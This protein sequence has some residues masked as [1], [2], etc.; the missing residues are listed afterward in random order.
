MTRTN[1]MKAV[2]ALLAVPAL[3]MVAH[4]ALS[5]NEAVTAVPP[6]A[7]DRPA[8]GGMQ[9]IVLA[10][11]CF[12]GLQGLFE[13]VRG[14]QQV[15][16]GYAGGSAETARY[17]IV[18]TGSTG[19]AESVEIT[20][21]PEVVSYGHLLQLY[22]SVA[23]DP[24]QIGGQGPDEGTQYRSAIFY[25]DPDQK[26]VADAYIAQIDTSNVFGRRLATRL[27][28]LT[29]FFPAEAYHQDYLVHHPSNPYIVVNDLPKISNLKRAFP[30]DYRSEPATIAA[31]S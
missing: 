17:P 30:E 23:H 20:Y 26:R 8:Q 2:P 9:K 18:S 4:G 12:W 7:L 14:V 16:S 27:E 15:V 11:G 13:H 10:G 5:A 29:G 19:H 25:A 28:P 1:W 21:N 24:T 6:P 3:F 22:F 31:R